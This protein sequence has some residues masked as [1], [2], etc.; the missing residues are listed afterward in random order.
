MLVGAAAVRRVGV[1]PTVPTK[2]GNIQQFCKVLN[3]FWVL[4][5]LFPVS[6]GSVPKWIKGADLKSARAQ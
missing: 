6:I 5:L 2:E 3:S 1:N 4:F